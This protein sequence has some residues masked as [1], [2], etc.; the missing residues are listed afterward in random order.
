[1]ILFF[2]G[3]ENKNFFNLIVSNGVKNVLFSYFYIQKKTDLET[4]KKEHDINV[5]MDS[6]GFSARTSGKEV[7]VEAY[8]RYL[9]RNK[10]YLF[11]AANLDVND[12]ETQLENQ[13]ILEEVYPV[14]PVYHLA[15]YMEKKRDLLVEYCD[16]YKYVALGG[17]IGTYASKENV[18]KFLTYCFSIG[19]KKGTKFHGFGITSVPLLKE[20]PFYSCDSTAWLSGGKFGTMKKWNSQKYDFLPQTHY[21]ERDKMLELNID[22]KAIDDYNLRLLQNIREYQKMEKDITKLWEIRGIKWL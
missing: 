5:F 11:T 6:G 16:K 4:L 10:D 12:L 1:M 17:M 7:S 2:A 13:K 18:K 22:V 20:F 3:A 9:E 8:K 15:E 19:L 21:G 14:L